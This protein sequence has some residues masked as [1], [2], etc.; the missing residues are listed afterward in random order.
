MRAWRVH[1]F[2]EPTEALQLDEVAAPTAGPGELLVR[3]AATTLNFNDVDGVR[4]RYRTVSPPLPYTPGMEVLGRVEDAGPGAE[5]WVGKRVVA[6]P[7]GA[8]G[9]YAEL[10]VGPSAMAFEMPSESALPDT[11]AAAV[12]FPFHLSWLALH[13][14]ARIQAGETVL[15]HAAAGGIG[16]AAVQLATLAGARV[17]A[18]AGSAAKLELCRSLG[19]AVAINYREA[20]FV[21]AVLQAT[22]GRGVDVAFDSVGGEVTTKTFGCMAFNGRHL[23]VGFASGIEAEDVGIVPR[24]VLFGSFS[25]YGVCHAYVDDPAALKA[26]SGYNFP[27]HADGD[28]VHAQILD[29]VLAGSLRPVVGSAVAFSDLPQAL[30]SMANRDTMGRNVVLVADSR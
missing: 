15:I 17:I 16:S 13:E 6:I 30:Q 23:L 7:S 2:G 12:Y 25:L 9:G 28:R 11:P 26:M 10:A 24:P 22:D 20:D 21:D 19:A 27:S 5:G 14:R 29:L 4:G 18:T 3:V 8:F 1:E